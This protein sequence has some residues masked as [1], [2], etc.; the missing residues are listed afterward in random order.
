MVPVVRRRDQPEA[1]HWD[2]EE[3]TWI[4]AG[5]EG[6]DA[7]VH[8]AGEPI[9]SGPWT[10]AQRRRIHDSRQRGTAL[11]ATTLASMARRRPPC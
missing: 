11:L 3:G 6:L 5:L 1:V 8:L 9:A 2:P 4:V 7:I 10:S